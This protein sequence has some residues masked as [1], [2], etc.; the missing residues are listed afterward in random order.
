M[1]RV[2]TTVKGPA[3]INL[4]GGKFELSKGDVAQLS[5]WTG[6]MTGPNKAEA[7]GDQVGVLVMNEAGGLA[8]V[9]DD[10]RVFWLDELE[11]GGRDGG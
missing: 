2:T 5:I 1:T 10:G 7:I 11:K 3:K 6:P 9:R 8:A 4:D